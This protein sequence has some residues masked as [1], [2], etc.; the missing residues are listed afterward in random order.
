MAVIEVDLDSPQDLRKVISK[1][2][3]RRKKILR[4]LGYDQIHFNGSK[5]NID[6]LLP[7]LNKMYDMD[8]SDVYPSGGEKSYFVYAH[9]NPLKPLD[10][11]NN[12]KHL[13]LASRFPGLK[14]EPFYIGKGQGNRHI[15]LNRNG[16]HRKIRTMI[17]RFKKEIEV[18]ILEDKLTSGDALAKEAKLMDI[19]GMSC[20]SNHGLLCNLDE[21]TDYDSRRLSYGDNQLIQKILKRNGYRK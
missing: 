4:K 2:Q 8:L 13:F 6:T 10:V 3:E 14:Y 15:D 12:L 21:G 19:L 20:F 17:T 1:L 11:K 5:Y 7:I 9:T 16:N 18:V